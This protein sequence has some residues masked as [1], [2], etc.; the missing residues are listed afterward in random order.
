MI[1]QVVTRPHHAPPVPDW[2]V[3]VLQEEG[4]TFRVQLKFGAMTDWTLF[5]DSE[6]ELKDYLDG[7]R[8]LKG[9]Q[10]VSSWL[11]SV[12]CAPSVLRQWSEWLNKG[13]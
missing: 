12:G 5:S 13:D 1:V 3:L 4:M 2:L 7:H 6:K 10:Y 9:N 8:D 11:R